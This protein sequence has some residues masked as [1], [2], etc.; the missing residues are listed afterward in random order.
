MT[1][2]LNQH[3]DLAPGTGDTNTALLIAPVVYL[4][5]PL[6]DPRRF[7]WLLLQ[8]SFTATPVLDI[9]AGKAC[10]GSTGDR[11]AGGINV[12]A[13]K[14]LVD[15]LVEFGR[16]RPVVGLVHRNLPEDDRG[17]VT[18]AP[19]HVAGILVGALL[20]D[21]VSDKLPAGVRDDGKDAQRIAGIHKVGVLRIVTPIG[22]ETCFAQ[23]VGVAVMRRGG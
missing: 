9:P 3:R 18:V 7:G 22:G 10:N 2:R 15:N 20:E 23:L 11:I 5:S 21:I 12:G 14:L 1:P 19:N 6:A 16:N 8:A 17:T 4:V 13:G